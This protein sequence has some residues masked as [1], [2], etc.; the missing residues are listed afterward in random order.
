MTTI[1]KT[2][3]LSAPACR[4]LKRIATP[5]ALEFIAER[6]YDTLQHERYRDFAVS[7]QYSTTASGYR[8]AARETQHAKEENLHRVVVALTSTTLR[9][10][11]RLEVRGLTHAWQLEEML[12]FAHEKGLLR[13]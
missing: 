6:F 2:L 12:F 5:A 4:A 13:V 1:T 9:T 7:P 8:F 11:K 3:Q 10:M